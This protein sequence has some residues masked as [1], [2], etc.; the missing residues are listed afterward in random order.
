MR[1]TGKTKLKVGFT[2]IKENK[3]ITTHV[4]CA[5]NVLFAGASLQ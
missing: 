3:A 2:V 5:S 1:K 4:F